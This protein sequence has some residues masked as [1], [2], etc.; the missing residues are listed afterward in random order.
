[1]ARSVAE[2]CALVTTAWCGS[3]TMPLIVPVGAC[4]WTTNVITAAANKTAKT[5]RTS[6]RFIHTL[7]LHSKTFSRSEIALQFDGAPNKSQ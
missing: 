1:V 2:T 3:V 5:P 4:A 6:L 7:R